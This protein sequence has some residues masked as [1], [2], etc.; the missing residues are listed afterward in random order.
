[1]KPLPGPN[2]RVGGRPKPLRAINQQGD[3]LWH[4][5]SMT[6][7][8]EAGFTPQMIRNVIDNPTQQ[9]RGMFWIWV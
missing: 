4:F 7:A 1:M 5:D 6:E 2:T 8:R 9:Y 3:T